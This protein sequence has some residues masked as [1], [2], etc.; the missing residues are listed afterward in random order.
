MHEHSSLFDAT[1]HYLIKIL[2]NKRNVFRLAIKQRIDN[3]FN[4]RVVLE[5]FEMGGGSDDWMVG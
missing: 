2:K 5:M 1:F 4:I 3:V